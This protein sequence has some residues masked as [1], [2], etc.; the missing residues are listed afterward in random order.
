MA[1][2]QVTLYSLF[3]GDPD[4]VTGWYRKGF[5]IAYARVAIVPKGNVKALSGLGVYSRHDAVGFTD[6]EVDVG[7]VV[8]DA[9]DDYYMVVGREPFKWGDRFVYYALDLEQL[10]DFPFS[11]GFFGFEDTEHGSIGYEFEDGFQRGYWAL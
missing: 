8:Q 3:L 5:T 7:D 10:H 4:S 11:A 9:F 1:S 6:Y 2:F